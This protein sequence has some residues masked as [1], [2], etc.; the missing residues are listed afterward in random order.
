MNSRESQAMNAYHVAGADVGLEDLAVA[1][2]G[3][4]Q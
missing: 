1:E 3:D 4:E 2:V